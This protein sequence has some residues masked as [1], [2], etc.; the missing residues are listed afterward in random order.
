MIFSVAFVASFAL[1]PAMMRL[2]VRLGLVD[3]PGGRRQHRGAI[4]RLGGA[5]VFAGFISAGLLVFALTPPPPGTQDYKLLS[6]V[7]AGALFVF[8]F[9]LFDDV[10]NLPPWPQFAAQFGAALIAIGFTIF[11]ERVTLPIKGET[12]FRWFITYPL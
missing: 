8:A 4:S 11:I 3:V 9:G 2:G 12:T 5:A 1:T 7:I 6:G 10:F